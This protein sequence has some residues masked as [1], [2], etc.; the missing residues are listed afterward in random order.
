[1]HPLAVPAA[2]HQL[3]RVVVSN[4]QL[5][6]GCHRCRLGRSFFNRRAKA[7]QIRP[8]RDDRII[9]RAQLGHV[10][11]RASCRDVAHP[12]FYCRQGVGV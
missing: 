11:T 6:L 1:M 12:I 9:G 5:R 3:E 4:C 7:H 8:R 2:W 10:S